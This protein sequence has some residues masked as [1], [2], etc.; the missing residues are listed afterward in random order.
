[1]PTYIFD[2]SYK[3]EMFYITTIRDFDIE[4]QP[5]IAQ[6][7]ELKILLDD[8]KC[9]TEQYGGERY[10]VL[11]FL[12]KTNGELV[13]AHEG[14]PGDIIPSH[15][16]MSGVG[17]CIDAECITAGNAFFDPES[18][19]LLILNHKSGD[20]RPSFNSLQ[21][22]FLE[23]I[24]NKISLAEPLEVQQ[25]DSAGVLKESYLINYVEMNSYSQSELQNQDN[26]QQQGDNPPSVDVFSTYNENENGLGEPVHESF[27]TPV[28]TP[29]FAPPP[30]S[31]ESVRRDETSVLTLF[32]D[33]TFFYYD[34]RSQE[35]HLAEDRLAC[36]K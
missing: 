19:T 27:A 11:R 6:A 34:E 13:F 12:L 32:G 36:K 23:L 4:D 14:S 17:N 33:N 29:I 35:Q 22:V 21:F 16:Q 18:H 28:Y 30:I 2:K 26:H 9:H 5:L 3:K 25:L 7:N 31:S 20:F 15:W 1:M 8:T 24:K 10:K